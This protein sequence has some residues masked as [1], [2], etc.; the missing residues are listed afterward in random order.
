M[1]MEM[2]FGTGDEWT[3]CGNASISINLKPEGPITN[4]KFA[5]EDARE[6]G[7]AAP[8]YRTLNSRIAL[9]ANR[10]F[11]KHIFD[12][13]AFLDRSLGWRTDWDSGHW[14]LCL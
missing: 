6:S 1:I 12:D 4:S 5:G 3:A 2:V 10:G 11:D 9:P 14:R 7:T 13:T 8:T